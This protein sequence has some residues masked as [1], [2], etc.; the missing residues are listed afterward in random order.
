M[1]SAVTDDPGRSSVSTEEEAAPEVTNSHDV[2]ESSSGQEPAGLNH[3]GEEDISANCVEEPATTA[4]KGASER[5]V[6]SEF[7][8]SKQDTCLHQLVFLK[9]AQRP[10]GG[11]LT[12][13]PVAIS[14]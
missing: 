13:P 9:T 6:S 11:I 3:S 5:S 10:L 12:P 4:P 8:A 14:E 7:V 1:S 2:S